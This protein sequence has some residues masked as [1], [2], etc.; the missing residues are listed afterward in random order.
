MLCEISK[1]QGVSVLDALDLAE[2]LGGGTLKSCRSI[3]TNLWKLQGDRADK[4]I[5]RIDTMMGY[6]D[7]LMNHGIK[8]TKLSI[9]EGIGR[10]EPSAKHLLKRL[11]VLAELIKKDGG[12]PNANFILSTVHSAKGLEYDT[13]YLMDVIDRIMPETVIKNPFTAPMEDILSNEED[14]RLFYVAATRAKNRLFVLTYMG[15]DS[16]FCDEFLQKNKPSVP[17]E[18]EKACYE[19]DFF[20]FCRRYQE[21][22]RIV[23]KKYGEGTVVERVEDMVAIRFGNGAPR[24]FSLTVLYQKTLTE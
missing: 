9:L 12:N 5:D 10:N 23:H 24:K 11:P 14:R 22:A 2:G 4:A 17:K 21:G 19:T 13:V 15:E 16:S 3:Q 7:Y 1:T 20:T 18:G 6:G 8:R